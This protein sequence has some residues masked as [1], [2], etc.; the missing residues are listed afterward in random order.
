MALEK[1][2]LGHILISEGLITEQQLSEALKTQKVLGKKIGEVLVEQKIL[3]EEQ[4][5]KAIEIQSGIL[6]IDLNEV[7][8]DR[9]AIVL[10]PRKLCE[11]YTLIPFGF[12]NNRLKAALADPLNTSVVNDIEKA[13]GFEIERYI[14]K[15]EDIKK[16]IK[17]HYSNQNKIR[18]SLEFWKEIEGNE[19][20]PTDEIVDFLLRNAIE[21][22]ASEIHI[23]LVED[24]VRIRYRIDG[25]LQQIDRF[26]IGSFDLIAEKIKSISGLNTAE[27]RMPQEGR[28]N[29]RY[30]D[31]KFDVYL[32]IST[33][34]IINGEKIFIRIF[35]N[36]INSITKQ[37]FATTKENL[38]KFDSIIS[39]PNGIILFTGSAG[40]GK[41][42]SLYAFLNELNKS[43][44]NIITIE[45]SVEYALSGINQINVNAEDGFTYSNALK[46]ALKQH[47]EI[48]VIDEI[49]DNETAEIAAKAAAGGSLVLSTMNTN[50][51]ISSIIRLLDM[52]IKPYL[53]LNF[54]TG[55]ISQQLVNKICPKCGEEYEAGT[56]EKKI[57]NWDLNKSLIL[58][59]GKGCDFCSGTGYRGR[60]AIYEVINITKE[61]RETIILG[62]SSDMLKGI[63]KENS[64]AT[65]AHECREAVTKGITTIDQVISLILS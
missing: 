18:S 41:T 17:V 64:K 37:N 14:A 62:E 57:L 7:E 38:K 59:R 51:Q 65:L 39:N 4:I 8:F 5:I 15:S 24:K 29:Y 42:T 3:N 21:M 2:K 22:R 28:I 60:V 34:P 53:I 61:N 6:K 10:V 1:K 25:K 13:T 40:S 35:D 16:S 47:P 46:N 48:I 36:K 54:V 31:E 44:I 12:E 26:E 9:N 43:N 30:E 45:E 52:G 49:R 56:E 11:K 50:Y 33:L 27:K 63:L 23:E 20:L 55:I 19:N 32:R 58:R